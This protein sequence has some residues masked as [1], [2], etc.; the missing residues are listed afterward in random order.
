MNR[1]TARTGGQEVHQFSELCKESEPET[2]KFYGDDGCL[3]DVGIS[4][5]DGRWRPSGAATARFKASNATT[6]GD[7]CGPCYSFGRKV[8][9]HCNEGNN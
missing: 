3:F 7:V 2:R 9:G 4:M 1:W 6:T 5:G 8:L